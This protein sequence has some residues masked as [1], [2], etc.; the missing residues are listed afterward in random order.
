[1]A[2]LLRGSRE[3]LYFAVVVSVVSAGGSGV[4]DFSRLCPSAN[5]GRVDVKDR[6]DLTWSQQGIAAIG[7]F[8]AVM[9]VVHI[10]DTVWVSP[11]G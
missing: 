9:C 8:I 3:F 5:G 4:A 2:F 10:L 7:V 11:E 1:M 6:S